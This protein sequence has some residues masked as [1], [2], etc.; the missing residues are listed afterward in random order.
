MKKTTTAGL[1]IVAG[2]LAFV[3]SANAVDLIVNGSFENP[4]NGW[5]Y[6]L[7]Y[8]YSAA[9]YA[10]PP[11]PVSE[12]PGSLWSWKHASV[13]G[14]WDSFATPTN[15]TDFPQYDLQFADSQTVELTNALSGAAIDGGLGQYTFSAWLAS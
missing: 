3:G 10:G 8:N 2:G 1:S 12:G 4:T 14:A 15:I 5:A 11:V 13:S 9:Y 6:F 7:T